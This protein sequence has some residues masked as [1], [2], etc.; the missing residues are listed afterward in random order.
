M[1]IKKL[2]FKKNFIKSGPELWE[3]AKSVIPGGNQLLSKRSERFLP[4]KWPAYFRYAK[5]CAVEDLDG[6]KFYDFAA[7]G[8]G[9][10]VL[11]YSDPEVNKA[12]HRAIEMGSMSTLNSY[13]EVALAKELIQLHPWSGMCRFAR[14]GGEACA[15]AVRI[16]RASSGRPNVAFCGY[17]GWHDWYLSA[18]L[19]KSSNLD[20]QL[21][22][23]LSSKGLPRN[24]ASTSFPFRYNKIEQLKNILYKEK[25]SIG[26][27]IME[28]IREED[29]KNSFLEQVRFLADENK[30]V[31]IFDEITSGFRIC[32]GGA[33]LKLGVNPDIV[34]L[35]KALGNGFPI[36]AVLGKRKIM[37]AAQ[38]TFIS[39]T[40]WTER[41]GFTAGLATIKKFKQVKAW[42]SLIENGR[43]IKT[44][45]K[46]IAKELGISLN[47]TGIDPLPNF[48][49]NESE[50]QLKMTIFTKEMLEQG[51][52]ASSGPYLSYA[53]NQAIIAKYLKA[54]KKTLKKIRE[55]ELKNKLTT[56]LQGKIANMGFIRLTS[57]ETK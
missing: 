45:W 31:L 33:H 16:A 27:I 26:T 7:M 55:H 21:L 24:L 32:P 47:I 13:E 9:S 57:H 1:N 15:I 56:L 2:F 22:P 50:S 25:K 51:F 19:S 18:N 35:G 46:E 23:G 54:C 41:I 6:N 37:D 38:D 8:V 44:G 43:K 30:C 17:H 36:S 4:G 28:P 53:H 40:F 29:P 52:L 34:V 49:F 20:D 48:C 14:S 3:E 10:C 12:V 11:G 39:S 5:G 42:Q